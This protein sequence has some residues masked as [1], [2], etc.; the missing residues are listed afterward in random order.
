[1]KSEILD[2]LQKLADA[3]EDAGFSE[4]VVRFRL[5]KA[6]P[7]ARAAIKSAKAAPPE[8]KIVQICQSGVGASA[9]CNDGT[10]WSLFNGGWIIAPPIPQGESP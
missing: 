5:E 3:A 4:S 10:V 8:R 6:L 7:A 9:L 1:M 2:A